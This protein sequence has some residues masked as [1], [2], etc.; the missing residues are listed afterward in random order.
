MIFVIFP[1]F[2]ASRQS[3]KTLL[4]PFLSASGE[5]S[6]KNREFNF[7]ILQPPF[8]LRIFPAR[9][10]VSP[11]VLQLNHNKAEAKETIKKV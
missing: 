8:R 9:R 1:N 3:L 2:R 4:N 11:A 7:S 6:L 10:L 5:N